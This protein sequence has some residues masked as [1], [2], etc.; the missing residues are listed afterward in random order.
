MYETDTQHGY[1]IGENWYFYDVNTHTVNPGEDHYVI[2]ANDGNFYKFRIKETVFTSRTDGELTLLA[3][4]VKAPAS[5]E[6]APVIGRVL[7]A[8]FPLIGGIPTFFSLKEG[9]T[10]DIS[11]ATTS[12]GWDLQSDFVTIYTN[13]GTSGPGAAEAKMYTDTQFDSIKTVPAGKY[14]TDD[15]SS[16]NYAIG[17]SW[18]NYDFMTHTLSLKP[19]VYVMKAADGKY[20]KVE[21]I[22]ANFSGQSGGEAVI[23]YQ[24]VEGTDF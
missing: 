5:A 23:K 6:T 10:V 3:A 20:A 22:A 18:Y 13:G 7:T 11:D 1:Y 2:K 24:Y 15:S 9:K 14:V 21:I 12:L 16:S 17:D 4:K 8:R 19:A